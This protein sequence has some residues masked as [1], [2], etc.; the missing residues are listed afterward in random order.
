MIRCCDPGCAPGLADFDARAK[1]LGQELRWLPSTY[2]SAT[3]GGLFGGGFGGAGSINHGPL[4]SASDLIVFN[5]AV[6]WGFPSRTQPRVV[7]RQGRK[8]RAACRCARA[9]RW[10][11]K[12]GRR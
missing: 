5:Q 7:L 2:R 9:R 1:P 3:L 11:A 8:G 10:R 6:R 4:A 12:P